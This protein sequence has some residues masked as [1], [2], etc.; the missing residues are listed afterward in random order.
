MS[1][2]EHNIKEAFATHDSKTKFAGKDAIW[3][4][5]NNQLGQRKGVAAFWRV[6]A[7]LIGFLMFTGVFAAF[8]NSAKQKNEIE[9]MEIENTRLL[10]T[11]DS[12]LSLPVAT[13]TEIQIVEKEKIVYR[14]RLINQQSTNTELHWEKKYKAL[15]DSTELVL[16]NINKIYNNEI[17][18][19]NTEIAAV[20]MELTRQQKAINEPEKS[21]Q[22]AP[23]E[24]KSERVDVD[25]SK[26]PSTR[27]PEM[28]MKVFQKNFIEN[29]NNLNRT[30]FK[31]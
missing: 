17:E 27:T 5:L 30:I 21:N 4:R 29:R 10:V 11:I 20:K 31:K 22:S 28:E 25:V 13:Q 8:N 9:R 14:D 7:I 16:A 26:K 24:L 15:S 6:A 19:L 18:Q 1:N 2:L 3:S 12:L 23:F